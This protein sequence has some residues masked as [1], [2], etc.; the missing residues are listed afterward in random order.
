MESQVLEL[1]CPCCDATL[2]FGGQSQRMT[3]EYCGNEF[4]LDTLKACAESAAVPQET[5]LQWDETE[6]A[7]WSDASQSGIRAFLCEDCGGE[8]LTDDHT[9]ATFC[10]YCGNAAILPSRLSGGLKPEGVIPFQTTKEDAKAAFQSLCRG[11]PLLPKF[12]REEQQLEKITGIYVPFWLYD[13]GADLNGSYKATRIHTW[14]DANYTYTKTDHYLLRRQA[15][16]LFSGIPMDASTKMDDRFMESIEPYDYS[17]LK[18]FDT[19]YLSGYLAD[20]Y[21]VESKSGEERIRQRVENAMEDALQQSFLGYATVLPTSRQIQIAHSQ[22]KYVL[23]PVWML[24]T[25]Y[26]GKTYTFTMNGQTGK[27]TGTL[28]VCKKRAAGWFA[29]LWAAS[30]ALI[31]LLMLIF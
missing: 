21:D 27:M 18:D 5:N 10:P 16:A 30:T 7:Q 11:K 19:L 8:L 15:D 6:K 20:K 22:A 25:N 23:L 14:S 28:P 2:T 31:A 13:C 3:C 26:R 29:G 24:N 9:A 17:G 4:D 1:K 12:F